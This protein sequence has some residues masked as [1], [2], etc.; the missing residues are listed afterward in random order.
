LSDTPIVPTPSLRALT[1]RHRTKASNRRLGSLLA[2]VAGAMNAGGFL[3]L[4]RYT[5]HMTGIVSGLADD[6]ALGAYRALA[7]GLLLVASFVLGAIVTAFLAN[8]ARQRDWRGEYAPC[9]AVEGVLLLVFATLT[10]RWGDTSLGIATGTALLCFVMGLQNA[11]VTKVSRAEIRTTHVTGILTDIGIE[12]GRWIYRLFGGSSQAHPVHVDTGR[13]VLLASLLAHF[14]A[15]GI[16][17]AFFFQLAGPLAAVPLGLG[18]LLL[19][20]PS[21]L[22]DLR[23][24]HLST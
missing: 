4:H 22:Y 14:V 19:A 10:F 5:S 21:L 8:W 17:G 23:N 16:A 18:L 11:M 6:L 2:F 3:L 7:T 20:T 12:V 9:L 15:G 24:A 1:D 13:L